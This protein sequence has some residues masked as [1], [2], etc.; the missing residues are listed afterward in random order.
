MNVTQ[1]ILLK[2]LNPTIAKKQ[3]A[4][5]GL[6]VSGQAQTIEKMKQIASGGLTISGSPRYLSKM[7]CSAT[8]GINV[9]G[10]AGFLAKLACS[11]SGGLFIS[12]HALATILQDFVAIGQGRLLVSGQASYRLKPSAFNYIGS[13]E[14]DIAGI[15]Q[16]AFILKQITEGEIDVSGHALYAHN[17]GKMKFGV[18]VDCPFAKARVI[19]MTGSARVVSPSAKGET[20]VTEASSEVLAPSGTAKIL[21]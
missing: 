8:G 2:L 10:A 5:G 7:V 16:I 12:G 3:V 18:V 21:D 6:L 20:I 17:V 1:E 11:P 13:G 9:G 4:S 15:S 14:L 19:T